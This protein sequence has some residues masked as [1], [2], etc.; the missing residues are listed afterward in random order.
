MILGKE[1]C[2]LPGLT[3]D[4]EALVSGLALLDIFVIPL[5]VFQLKRKKE[6]AEAL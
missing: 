6:K 2:L 1:F 5:P 3:S 4:T